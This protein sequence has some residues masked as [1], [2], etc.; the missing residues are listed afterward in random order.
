MHTFLNHHSKKMSR[1]LLLELL[2]DGDKVSIYS[3]KFEGEE[4]TEFEKFILQYKDTHAE[5]LQI[6]VARIDKIKEDGA[7]DRHFRYEGSKR[8]NVYALPSHFDSTNLRLYCLIIQH[9]VIILG[10]GGL[11]TTRTYNEDSILN[12]EVETLQKIDIQ[13]KEK[14]KKRVI[15]IRGTKLLGELELTID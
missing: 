13:I 2:E 14:E 7:E 4:Y 15:Y 8:D 9:K 6:I 1:N 10:N 12:N 5:D 11:K 3:P